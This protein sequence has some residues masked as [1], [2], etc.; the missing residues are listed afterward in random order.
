MM[1][2][3]E[4]KCECWVYT[5][6]TVRI[7]CETEDGGESEGERYDAKARWCDGRGNSNSNSDSDSS[8]STSELYECSCVCVRSSHRMLARQ[9]T[10]RMKWN[11]IE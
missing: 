5:L 11:Q 1:Q 8:L 4:I 3:K 2:N 10:Q 7:M 6:Y 9:Y